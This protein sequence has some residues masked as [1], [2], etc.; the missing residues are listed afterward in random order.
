MILI[1]NLFFISTFPT[2]HD[3]YS[4]LSSSSIFYHSSSHSNRQY[5]LTKS[6]KMLL[7]PLNSRIPDFLTHNRP[8]LMTLSL[9]SPEILNHNMIACLFLLLLTL[10]LTELQIKYF[11]S[12][13][14]SSIFTYYFI[15]FI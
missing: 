3:A 15:F 10:S 14:L 4:Y 5:I 9:I 12:I 11:D 13:L 7:F 2:H 8:I 1:L 6:S